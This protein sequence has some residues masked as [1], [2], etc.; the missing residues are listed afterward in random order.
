MSLT[1]IDA[2]AVDRIINNT[3]KPCLLIFSKENCHVCQEVVP[4]IEDLAE[5]FADKLLFYYIDVENNKDILKKYALKG[6]PQILFFKD[7]EFYG[8]LAGN[9]EEEDIEEKISE[10]F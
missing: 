5:K 8:K 4:R 6:V 3:N 2:E 10:L 9:V 1:R 7:G